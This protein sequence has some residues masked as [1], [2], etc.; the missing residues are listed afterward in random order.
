MKKLLFVSSLL[1]AIVGWSD[2][3]TYTFPAD[4]ENT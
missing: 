2:P 1:A 4:R 3:V